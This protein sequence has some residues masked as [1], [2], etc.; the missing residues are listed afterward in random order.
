LLLTCKLET[1]VSAS[2]GASQAKGDG[3]RS[4]DSKYRLM[5]SE[6]KQNLKHAQ[7]V[8]ACVL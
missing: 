5:R 4:L 7:L 8:V 3:D 6:Q 2:V 1:S